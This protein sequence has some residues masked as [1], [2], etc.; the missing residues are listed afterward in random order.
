MSAAQHWKTALTH[1][2]PNRVSIRGH[3]I[4]ELMGTHSFASCVY[5]LMQGELPGP[6]VEGVV[7]AVLCACI[8]HGVTPPSALATRTV[9][10]TGAS[11]SASVAAGIMAIN[12]HHGGAIENCALALGEVIS[13]AE[14]NGDL[15][16][17]AA[18]LLADW[19]SKGKRVPGFGHRLHTADPRTARMLGIASEAGVAGSF[20]AAAE[21]MEKA[22]ASAGKTLPLNVDGAA[23]A[24]LADLGFEP[25]VMNGFFM[26]ARCA[27]LIAHAREE[28]QRMKPMR[29]IDPLDHAYDGPD[30]RQS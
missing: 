15:D 1:I 24:V 21:A 6:G 12:R 28:S 4:S 27:G 26:I 8:D 2:E 10:S 30:L 13:R 22:F 19:S 29:I 11:L 17:A 23:A 16:A 3:D 18:E 5:L 25:P 7:D 14:G 20:C 9:A